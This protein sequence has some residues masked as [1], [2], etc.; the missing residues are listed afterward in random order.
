[1]RKIKWNAYQKVRRAVKTG[2]ILRPCNC[3]KC[4]RIAKLHAHH[5]DYD[6]PFDIKWLC[7]SCH[8]KI[9]SNKGKT[10][11]CMKKLTLTE[12]AKRL[13]VSPQYIWKVYHGIKRVSP[14]KALEIEEVS[15]G[16]ITRQMLLPELFA[17]N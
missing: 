2:Q 8:R 4:G 7:N 1:M 10:Y 11:N 9:H 14:R 16:L 12:I 5:E 3:S 15:E 17:D 13:G 6:R